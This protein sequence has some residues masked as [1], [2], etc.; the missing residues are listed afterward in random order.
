MKKR[1]SSSRFKVKK[2]GTKIGY[3]VMWLFICLTMMIVEIFAFDPFMNFLGVIIYGKQEIDASIIAKYNEK[4]IIVYSDTTCYFNIK[5]EVCDGETKSESTYKKVI[6][7]G[8]TLT[9]TLED[10]AP[11]FFSD[12]AI[13]TDVYPIYD[14]YIKKFSLVRDKYTRIDCPLLVKYSTKEI[15]VFSDKS[16]F[17]DLYV[18]TTADEFCSTN[19][20]R[21]IK[22]KKGE[23]L[24]LTLEDL[25][26]GFFAEGTDIQYVDS[27][28]A[29]FK[30]K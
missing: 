22:I 30:K 23:T 29:T 25:A 18:S 13:I 4:E 24:T 15:T 8:Q 7:E 9:L 12:K 10:L 28:P 21:K 6:S 11:G 2:M 17:F 27:T 26:P 19:Y 5:V 16:C 14:T 20:Y 1:C 3:V